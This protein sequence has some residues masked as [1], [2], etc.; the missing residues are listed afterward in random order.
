[1]SQLLYGLYTILAK[2]IA[3]NGTSFQNLEFSAVTKSSKL[4]R[5]S[6]TLLF[7]VEETREEY[8]MKMN[9]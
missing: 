6:V 3:L 5:L 4:K 2:L 1:M 9:E 7:V 8:W